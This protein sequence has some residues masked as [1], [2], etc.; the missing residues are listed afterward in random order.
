MFTYRISFH[1]VFRQKW[2]RKIF[3]M[4][5]LSKLHQGLFVYISTPKLVT[6]KMCVGGL[7]T[8]MPFAGNNEILLRLAST[9][10]RFVGLESADG[11]KSVMILGES[12]ISHF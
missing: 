12:P 3:L 10:E 4:T 8:I 1:L 6:W 11:V 9:E 5:S 7:V 2:A